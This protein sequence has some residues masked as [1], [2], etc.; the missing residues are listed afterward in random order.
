[1]L[2]AGLASRWAHIAPLGAMC[3]QLE[4]RT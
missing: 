1:L 3:V 2:A 4:A